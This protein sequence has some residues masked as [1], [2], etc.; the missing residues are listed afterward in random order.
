MPY[1]R[2]ER[3][4][5][6]M[7]SLGLDMENHLMQCWYPSPMPPRRQD[8]AVIVIACGLIRRRA[9]QPTRLS[10][11]VSLSSLKCLVPL[12]WPFKV[13]LV[14]LV[15]LST[16]LAA[17]AWAIQD[18]VHGQEK[19]S[20][21]DR[22][23]KFGFAEKEKFD[24][25][26]NAFANMKY[27]DAVRILTPLA[28][29]GFVKA[30][31]VLAVIYS[32]GGFGVLANASEALIWYKKAAE[33]GD[34]EAQYFIAERETNPQE[35]LKWLIKS[36]NQ[37]FGQAVD[38]L[39]KLYS[40]DTSDEKMLHSAYKLWISAG[41]TGDIEAQSRLGEMYVTGHGVELDMIK[42]L[43]WLDLAAHLPG[44]VTIWEQ[45]PNPET[46]RN[47]IAAQM[48]AEDVKIADRLAENFRRE[49]NLR[50]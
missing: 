35:R 44:A 27:L 2:P 9:S 33:G 39:A 30:Q 47:E 8:L 22:M 42:G 3:K 23:S 36:A 37:D 13:G 14:G 17:P 6:V 41:S 40:Q 46:R 7:R 24:E 28:K 34:A 12:C 1:L 48:S 29:R 16:D 10:T 20:M 45:T 15:L 5:G 26:Y 43:M 19:S 21:Q 11:G 38:Q 31:L 49:H 32:N 25:G 4:V 50:S 18:G